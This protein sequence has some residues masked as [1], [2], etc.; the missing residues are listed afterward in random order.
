MP[1]K[2]NV[3]RT[4]CSPQT[5]QECTTEPKEVCVDQPGTIF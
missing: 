3:P 4:S 5:R 2:K 1:R